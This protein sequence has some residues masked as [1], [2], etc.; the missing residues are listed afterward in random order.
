M[1]GGIFWLL[2]ALVLGGIVHIAA[3]LVIPALA[4][5]SGYSRFEATLDANT[6]AVAGPAVPGGMPFPFASPDTL[7]VFCRYDV[8]EDPLQFTA[9]LPE[10]YWS[11]SLFEPDGGNYYYIDSVQAPTAN[12][13]LILL[14][15]GDEVD[16]GDRFIMTSAE[17]PRGL[18]V[19]RILLRDRTM[20]DTVRQSAEAAR[21][22][23][24]EVE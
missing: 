6:A 3:M 5:K 10:T 20:I 24:F 9:A 14:G 1:R 2:L 23:P 16:P 8:T 12:A 13:D 19:L 4:P 7:Y 11:L 15:T 18:L 22:E 17:H 21:C